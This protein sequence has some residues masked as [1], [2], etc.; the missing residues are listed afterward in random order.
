MIVSKEDIK[1]KLSQCKPWRLTGAKVEV[2]F[3]SFLAS[4]T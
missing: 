3:H 2:Q 1:V 4:P